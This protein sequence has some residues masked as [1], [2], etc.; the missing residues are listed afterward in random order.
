[1]KNNIGGFWNRVWSPRIWSA[2]QDDIRPL[3]SKVVTPTLILGGMADAACLLESAQVLAHGLPNNE[4]I[5]LDDAGHY[6]VRIW[7]ESFNRPIRDYLIR[8]YGL[9]ADALLLAHT[10]PPQRLSAPRILRTL[11]VQY[12]QW[13]RSRFR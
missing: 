11:V 10:E 12:W 13:F 2:M 3:L 7:P 8:Q 6:T 9:S 5:I 4:L 1:M